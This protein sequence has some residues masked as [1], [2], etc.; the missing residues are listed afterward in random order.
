MI[1]S[2]IVRHSFLVYHLLRLF[3]KIVILGRRFFLIKKDLTLFQK[4]GKIYILK[5]SSQPFLAIHCKMY[6]VLSKLD[7]FVLEKNWYK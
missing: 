4:A 2:T 5:T 3:L 7:Q 6:I 1:W